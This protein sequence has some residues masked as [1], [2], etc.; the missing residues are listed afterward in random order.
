VNTSP[1]NYH[2]IRQTQLAKFD[3]THWVRFGDV[4]AGA[5]N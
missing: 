1:T 4:I 5:G 3:G 2:P